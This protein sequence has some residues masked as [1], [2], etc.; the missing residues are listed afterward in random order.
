[1]HWLCLCLCLFCAFRRDGDD[2]LTL[3]FSLYVIYTCVLQAKEGEGEE[4]ERERQEQERAQA[5]ATLHKLACLQQ[6]QGSI[7]FY[8]TR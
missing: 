4:E 3:F 8:H 2:T 5:R 7:L 6:G 1:M